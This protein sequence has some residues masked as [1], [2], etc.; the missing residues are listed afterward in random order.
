MIH[1]L[2]AP[3]YVVDSLFFSSGISI[4]HMDYDYIDFEASESNALN[5]GRRVCNVFDDEPEIE[6]VVNYDDGWQVEYCNRKGKLEKRAEHYMN[7]DE[8]EVYR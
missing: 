3:R 4:I 2:Y 1:Q 5:F 7:S 6:L 8:K